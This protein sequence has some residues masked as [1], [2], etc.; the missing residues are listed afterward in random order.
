M[1][2]GGLVGDE[3]KVDEG[4]GVIVGVPVLVAV[5]V[6]GV[7]VG[8]DVLDGIGVSVAVGVFVG[9]LEG[10]NVKV[11]SGVLVGSGVSVGG[12]GGVGVQVLVGV[13]DGVQDMIGLATGSRR[14]WQPLAK[15]MITPKS[16]LTTSDKG[17]PAAQSRS[18]SISQVYELPALKG[19]D[20]P[21]LV[22]E[23]ESKTPS[24]FPP[25]WM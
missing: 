16:S 3:V 4:I 1:A 10:V 5:G 19:T 14:S 23:D 21:Q 22:G 11:G 8:C 6:I 9:V 2:V 24:P 12:G 17:P 7:F 15:S 20:P 18:K 13:E 25:R